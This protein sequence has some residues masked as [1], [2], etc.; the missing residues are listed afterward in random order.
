MQ[1]ELFITARSG[2]HAR[3]HHDRDAQTQNKAHAAMLHQLTKAKNG[4][5]LELKKNKAPK[6][7]AL[8]A[9]PVLKKLEEKQPLQAILPSVHIEEKK[10]ENKEDSLAD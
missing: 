10:Q 4:K 9:P 8:P 1:F 3:P 5:N 7:K 6:L 2:T